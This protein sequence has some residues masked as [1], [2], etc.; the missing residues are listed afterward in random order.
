L[1]ANLDYEDGPSL[2]DQLSHR[3]GNVKSHRT[4]A[5][6]KLF[7][8][9]VDAGLPDVHAR[10]LLEA[11][12]RR[13]DRQDAD[14]A[15]IL[16]SHAARLIED[17]LRVRG[18]IRLAS[19]RCQVVAFVGPTGV[20]KTTTIAKLAASFRLQEKARVGLI[21]VDTYRIAAVEQLRTYA[22]IMDLPMEV[23]STPGEMQAA[24]E[25]MADLDLVLIDTAGRSPRDETHIQELRD[26]LAEANVD[27]IQLVLSSVTSSD[28]LQRSVEQFHEV[29]ATHLV[30]TKI[31]EAV[32]LGS[33][34]PLLKRCELPVTYIT[35]GQSVPNDIF[36]AQKR[37]LARML[38]GMTND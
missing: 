32:G 29:G 23:V 11:V 16:K 5:S 13:V 25:R 31:D 2:V 28:A 17:Q 30:L 4:A 27:E 14:D 26:T 33:L 35:N 15:L 10:E 19:N 6:F 8:D 22:E 36:S 37:H 1:R 3:E 21:T 38:I 7:T 18:P 12:K 20:G 34:F 9:L 24:V